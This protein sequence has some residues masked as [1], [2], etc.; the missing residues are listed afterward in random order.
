MRSRC[1][2]SNLRTTDLNY[3]RDCVPRWCG[4]SPCEVRFSLLAYIYIES[5]M[6]SSIMCVLEVFSKMVQVG[7]SGP[8]L[9]FMRWMVLLSGNLIGQRGTIV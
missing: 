2:P 9:S 1:A 5:L 4:G 7:L 6:S 8:A 3:L